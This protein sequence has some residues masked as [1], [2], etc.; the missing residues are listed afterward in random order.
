ML[1]V[2]LAARQ[3]TRPPLISFSGHNPSQDTKWAAGAQWPENFVVRQARAFRS[4]IVKWSILSWTAR[5]GAFARM[6]LRSD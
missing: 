5:L 2:A 3:S 4:V 6:L 1:G